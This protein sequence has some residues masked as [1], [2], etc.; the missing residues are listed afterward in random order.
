MEIV[1]AR[2]RRRFVRALKRLEIEYTTDAPCMAEIADLGEGGA[3]VVTPN[4]F[5]LGT[6]LRYKFHLPDDPIAIEGEAKVTRIEPTLGMALEFEGLSREDQV[7]IR[8]VVAAWTYDP[9]L[10][11]ERT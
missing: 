5:P 3:F 2:T 6:R 8:L 1:Q 4:P 9:T 10:Q 7:R 11:A